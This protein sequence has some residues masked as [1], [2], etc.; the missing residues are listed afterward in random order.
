MGSVEEE[1]LAL[2]NHHF[3]LANLIKD[4]EL[5][6][7]STI[8]N[9]ERVYM[10]LRVRDKWKMEGRFSKKKA[11]GIWKAEY[12]YLISSIERSIEELKVIIE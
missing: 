7:T 10:C 3:D 11:T 2:K 4:V 8:D 9:L 12:K 5:I 1:K 6:A